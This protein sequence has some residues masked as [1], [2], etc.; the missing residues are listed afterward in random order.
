MY[1]F[2][3]E[4]VNPAVAGRSF[5]VKTGDYVPYPVQRM[6]QDTNFIVEP[7]LDG[8]RYLLYIPKDRNGRNILLSRHISTKTNI[9]VDKSDN[10]PHLRD[11][12]L[13][14]YTVLDGEIV[15]NGDDVTQFGNTVSVMGSSE[16]R[17]IERQKEIGYVEYHVF[18]L[19][20]LR[21]VPMMA[22]PDG[23]RRQQLEYY[24]RDVIE[25]AMIEDKAAVEYIHLVPRYVG[26]DG[27][28]FLIDTIGSGGEGGMIKDTRLEYGNKNAWI[29]VKRIETWDV[30]ITGFT[31]GNG[32]YGN[33]GWIGAIKYGLYDSKGNLHECG[34]TS[35]M[36]EEMR[37]EI[38]NRKEELIG[39]VV[40]IMGQYMSKSG[41]VR[42]PRFV[43]LRSDANSNEQTFEKYGLNDPVLYGGIEE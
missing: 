1:K 28:N 20:W 32:K 25:L 29:K 30:V 7:K 42:H 3:P 43:R 26:K 34:Q 19:L 15:G 17:A 4:F 39:S 13:E 5:V 16:E 37:A 38:S 31:D 21:G 10:V 11:I 33:N 24:F 27:I 2:I 23:I 6:L 12:K 8:S 36:D 35:G 22:K 18:D 41:T 9:P 14:G 40:E